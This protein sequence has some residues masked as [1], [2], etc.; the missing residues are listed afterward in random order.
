MSWANKELPIS[1]V[2]LRAH[3][4]HRLAWRQRRRLVLAS[5]HRSLTDAGN[6]RKIVIPLA[7]AWPSDDA[8]ALSK[9]THVAND[10]ASTMTDNDVASTMT[11]AVLSRMDVKPQQVRTNLQNIAADV[12]DLR[13]ALKQARAEAPARL[14]PEI[15]KLN[16]RLSALQAS[17]EQLREARSSL[18][19]RA[20]KPE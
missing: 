13:N 9:V 3:P 5:L 20:I 17:I 1:S 7:C 18:I 15:A 6:T 12:R 10:V 4:A 11:D 8:Q 16:E 14:D 19:D 2:R